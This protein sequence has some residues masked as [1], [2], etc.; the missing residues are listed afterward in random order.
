VTPLRDERQFAGW[1][2]PPIREKR[3]RKPSEFLGQEGALVRAFRRTPRGVKAPLGRNFPK[4]AI[5]IGYSPDIHRIFIPGSSP[6][7]VLRAIAAAREV[8]CRDE[9]G[10]GLHGSLAHPAGSWHARRER[11]IRWDIP[12]LR[13]RTMARILLFLVGITKRRGGRDRGSGLN[14]RLNEA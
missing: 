6:C 5:F 11:F 9:D 13:R 7:G 2:P 4:L 10:I 3:P 14:S 8:W 1:S 12:P